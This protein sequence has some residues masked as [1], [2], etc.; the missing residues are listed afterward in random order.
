[1]CQLPDEG[2]P[3]RAGERAS[4]Y[5]EGLSVHG[6]AR[7]AGNASP[8]SM[9]SP[10]CV[11]IRPITAGSSIVASTVMRPPHFGQA[12][13]SASNARRMSSAQARYFG[14]ARGPVASSRWSS[15]GV[16]DG[17]GSTGPA[18]GSVRATTA[19]RHGAFGA[20]TP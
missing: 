6:E 18:S 13:T 9:D 7:A 3:W 15:A 11:R 17:Q 8:A 16:G 1:M 10:T 12:R 5:S 19:R 14:R 4:F 2:M 20:R